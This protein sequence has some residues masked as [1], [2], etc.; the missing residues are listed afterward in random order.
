[1]AFVEFSSNY[2]NYLWKKFQSLCNFCLENFIPNKTKISNRKNSWLSREIIHLTQKV[3]RMKRRQQKGPL[4]QNCKDVLVNKISAAKHH[5]FSVTLPQFLKSDPAKFWRKLQPNKQKA[6]DCVTLGDNV[7]RDSKQIATKFNRYFHSVFSDST[8]CDNSNDNSVVVNPDF[9]TCKGTFSMLLNIKT[10]SC[11]PD[12]IPN[13]FLR[14][15][16]E[17]LA[18]FLVVIFRSSLSQGTDG[19]ANRPSDTSV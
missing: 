8:H 16:A 14:R 5:C 1:M 2:V 9:I 17:S 18:C 11:G 6:V 13:A 10:K 7:I 3:K 4:F 15:Y 19:M 12:S